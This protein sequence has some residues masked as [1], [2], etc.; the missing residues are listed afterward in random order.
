MTDNIPPPD[1]I[2]EYVLVHPFMNQT[3]DFVL[4]FEIGSLYRMLEGAEAEGE[5]SVCLPLHESNKGEALRLVDCLGWSLVQWESTN[6]DW[7][8]VTFALRDSGDEE[9]KGFLEEE[10]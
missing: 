7:A 4:G 1:D 3:R 9:P 6:P 10:E 2:G 8:W 5:S